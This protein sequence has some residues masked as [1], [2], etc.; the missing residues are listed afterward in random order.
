MNILLQ[1]ILI[2]MLA[3]AFILAVPKRFRRIVEGFSFVTSLYLFFACIKIFIKS[4]IH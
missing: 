2:S 1:P 4:S 3:G